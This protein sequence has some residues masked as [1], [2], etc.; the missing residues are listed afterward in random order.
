[1]REK[2]SLA[3]EF[4]SALHFGQA[5]LVSYR[6]LALRNAHVVLAD[7]TDPEDSCHGPVTFL[8]SA[9]RFCCSLTLSAKRG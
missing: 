4:C 9:A 8:R 7:R 1:M 2:R 3:N 6:P 5:L